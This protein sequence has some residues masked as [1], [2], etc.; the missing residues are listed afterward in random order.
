MQHALFPFLPFCSPFFF[1]SYF[2]AYFLS[3]LPFGAASSS[4]FASSLAWEGFLAS[5]ERF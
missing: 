4:F 2:L 5:V 3:F 1:I